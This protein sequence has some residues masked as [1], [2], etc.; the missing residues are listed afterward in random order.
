V[1]FKVIVKL[2]HPGLYG[3]FELYEREFAKTHTILSTNQRYINCESS[4]TPIQI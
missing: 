1:P 2:I 4:M 3:I